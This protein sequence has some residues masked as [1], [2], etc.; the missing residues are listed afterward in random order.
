MKTP[1]LVDLIAEWLPSKM[2]LDVSIYRFRED[3]A[4][5]VYIVNENAFTICY[6]D[7]AVVAYGYGWDQS[8]LT[9]PY[10][11]PYELKPCDPEFFD[12]LSAV[13]D[14]SID[15]EKAKANTDM[16]SGF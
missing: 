11:W 10:P 7:D 4:E 12:K 2:L 9:K 13:I 3:T 14:K 16:I 1:N 5:I 8:E 6:I 15:L